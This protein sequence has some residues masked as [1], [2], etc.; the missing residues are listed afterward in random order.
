MPPAIP[1]LPR[2]AAALASE[3]VEY[4]LIGGLALIL[5]GG[6][7]V[8]FDADIAIAFNRDNL[9]RIVRALRPLDPRPLRLA[10][11]A[12][13]V[14]DEKCVRPPWSLFQT[15]AGRLDL[16]LRLPGVESFAGVYGRARTLD[17]EGAKV[18]VASLE[19]LKAMKSASERERD[20]SDV[21]V[22]EALLRQQ[23]PS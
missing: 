20:L 15:E 7:R 9:S 8:T 12:A 23:G 11:G 3:E 4:V 21:R 17:I 6:D 19:D 13:W 18:R 14:W 2:L 10:Q 1:D 22:I 5:Q 16:I